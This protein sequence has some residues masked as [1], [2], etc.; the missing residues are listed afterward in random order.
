VGTPG[1]EPVRITTRLRRLLLGLLLRAITPP[2][3]ATGTAERTG[4]GLCIAP[5]V[6]AAQLSCILLCFAQVERGESCWR[7]FGSCVDCFCRSF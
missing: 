5:E 4:D 3:G 1:S 6:G 7:W 2:L